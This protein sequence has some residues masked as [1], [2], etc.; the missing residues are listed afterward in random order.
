MVHATPVSSARLVLSRVSGVMIAQ[1][2]LVLALVATAWASGVLMHGM[3]SAPR[4]LAYG[5][6]WLFVPFALWLVLSLAVHVAVGNKIAAHL[7]LIAGWVLAV[8][9]N[10]NGW[11]ESPWIRYGDL[12]PLTAGSEA[13]VSLALQ[14]TAWWCTVSA[15]LLVFAVHRWRSVTF[16][17]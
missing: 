2:T 11:A 4:A 15:L 7:L 5:V 9:L 17:R 14:Q 13:P 12:A 1:L 10:A 6:L 8:A 16:R 3:V